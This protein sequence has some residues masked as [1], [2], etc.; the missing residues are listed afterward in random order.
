MRP[1]LP[2]SLGLLLAVAFLWVT[3][4]VDSQVDP[5][6]ADPTRILRA[7]RDRE[8]DLRVAARMRMTIRRAGEPDRE[9][10]MRT[11]ASR[12]E[13][14]VRT[15]LLFESPANLRNMGLLTVDHFGEGRPDE[16]W[17]YLPSF[18]RTNRISSSTRAG[19]F[20][21]SDF[22]FS[23]F[24]MPDAERYETRLV[25][26]DSRVGDEPAWRL[27]ITPRDAA[28]RRET[29]YASAELWIGKRS[30]LALRTKAVAA[31]GGTTKYI[32][33]AGVREVD[34]VWMPRQLV[35]RTLRG[36]ELVSETLLEQ[37]EVSV[38]DASINDSLFTPSRLER[39]L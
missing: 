7:A 24:T 1:F 30:L 28:T 36:G 11:W 33:M 18:R 27:A 12:F 20:A 14:G 22:S 19:A 29:G 5:D 39:G 8:P 35:A 37:L 15:L 17:L 2:R 16:Q 25:D 9:R 3:S 4:S 6:E 26:A 13:G 34:G 38:N 23:D 21:G 31:R 10:T 32:Q